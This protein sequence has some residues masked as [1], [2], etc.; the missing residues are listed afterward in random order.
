M[1]RLF[2]LKIKTR[3]SY[4]GLDNILGQYCRGSYE[5]SI[6]GLDE[7]NGVNRKIM[8]LSFVEEG[9]R[10][11]IKHFFSVRAGGKKKVAG[12]GLLAAQPAEAA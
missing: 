5:I 1:A 2:G 3:L 10:E 4:E 11:R 7:A 9:D 12:T 8:V 6:G